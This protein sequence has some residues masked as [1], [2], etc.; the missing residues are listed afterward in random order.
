MRFRSAC[1]AVEK[2]FRPDF[3]SERGC[4]TQRAVESP[5]KALR[6]AAQR[7]GENA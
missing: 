2:T 5:G 1:G 4:G 3:H 7:A 6:E